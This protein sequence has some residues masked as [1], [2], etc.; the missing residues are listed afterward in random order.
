MGGRGGSGCSRLAGTRGHTGG[1][2]GVTLEHP[3]S[4]GR[5]AR[6]AIRG[7]TVDFMAKFRR[8][9]QGGER[10]L[11]RGQHRGIGSGCGLLDLSAR[12]LLAVQALL[13]DLCAQGIELLL[14]AQ[15]LPA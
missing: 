12:L 13:R 14:G 7:Q 5:Q 10:A 2:G 6:A 9:G 4:S 1:E 3:G 11:L 8:E 15:R